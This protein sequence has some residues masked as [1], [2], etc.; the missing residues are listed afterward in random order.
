MVLHLIVA[1]SLAGLALG[2][3]RSVM[4]GRKNSAITSHTLLPSLIGTIGSSPAPK[5][6]ET[7]DGVCPGCGGTTEIYP[8]VGG[9]TLGAALDYVEVC[10][11]CGNF[12][13]RPLSLQAAV[14]D[15][16]QWDR[17]P[18]GLWKRK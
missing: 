16:K 18:E 5:V 13:D 14:L 9:S 6:M 1:L 8:A 3:L 17:T 2:I 10:K 11:G 4:Q 7:P 12:I 15:P